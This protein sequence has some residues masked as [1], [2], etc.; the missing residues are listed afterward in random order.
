MLFLLAIL[1]VLLVISLVYFFIEL[2]KTQVQKKRMRQFDIETLQNKTSNLTT[3]SGA[4]D[5][6]IKA[7]QQQT[8]LLERI[9]QEG[10]GD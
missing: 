9:I 4:T 10:G 1:F 8:R 5:N 6:L 7:L 2:K 3:T